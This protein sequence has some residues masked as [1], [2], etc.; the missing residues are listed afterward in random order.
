M[1]GTAARLRRILRVRSVEHH[2]AQQRLAQAEKRLA[3]LAQIGDRIDD[4][5]RQVATGSGIVD[6]ASLKAAG[7]MA[8]RLAQA[9]ADMAAPLQAAADEHQLCEVRRG[10]AWCREEGASRLHM[11][12]DERE[13]AE[14]GRRA[15]A[16]RPHK[17]KPA[18]FIGKKAAR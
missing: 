15:D 5:R 13:A 12:A 8:E 9:T 3:A 6:G 16:N 17:A 10:A 2:I 14:A 4:L 18:K 1:S 7:E 11:Q